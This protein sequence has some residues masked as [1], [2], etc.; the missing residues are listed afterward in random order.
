[1]GTPLSLIKTHIDVA[2]KAGFK[3]VDNIYT[4]EGQ[5]MICFDDGWKGIY[6]NKEF[7]IKMKVFPTIFIAVEL[8]GTD[9]YMSIQQIKELIE[10]GYHFE[11]HAWTHTGLHT[12]TGNDLK[13]ELLD[14]RKWL[15]N[16]FNKQFDAICFPQGNYNDEVIRESKAA[17]YNRLYSSINGGYEDLMKFDGLICRNLVQDVTELQF[18]FIIKGD[19]PIIRNKR[20]KQHYYQS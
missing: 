12:Y 18:K 5:I 6:E 3:L 17:G 1:M 9:G 16:T 19:S 11:S 10:L 7:F 8:I 14:S 20:I 13:H 15:E 4:A 2:R